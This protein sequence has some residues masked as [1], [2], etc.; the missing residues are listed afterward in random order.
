VFKVAGLTQLLPTGR[1]YLGTSA[2]KRNSEHIGHSSD[3]DLT[4]LKLD[5]LQDKVQSV[6]FFKHSK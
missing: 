4:D 3:G 5:Y 6:K 1:V 2:N